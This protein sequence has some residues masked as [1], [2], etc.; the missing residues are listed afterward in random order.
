VTAGALLSQILPA[1]AAVQAAVGYE[2]RIRHDLSRSQPPIR[3]CSDETHR[4]HGCS[5]QAKTANTQ[6]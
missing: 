1:G 4:R 2:V 3:P 6:L 5:S